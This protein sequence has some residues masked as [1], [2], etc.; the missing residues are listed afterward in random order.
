MRDN[1]Q[2]ERTE[3]ERPSASEPLFSTEDASE[4]PVDKA[5]GS[6]VV[7]IFDLR[8]NLART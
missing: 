3:P 8:E 4:L 7:G 1:P 6:R 2:G 5:L